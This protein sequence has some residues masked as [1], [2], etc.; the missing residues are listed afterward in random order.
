MKARVVRILVAAALLARLPI[1]PAS[2]FPILTGVC[3]M[4]YEVFMERGRNAPWRHDESAAP[5]R[6]AAYWAQA[7]HVT[8]MTHPIWYRYTRFGENDPC[9]TNSYRWL[10]EAMKWGDVII[11]LPRVW[12][13]SLNPQTWAHEW[14]LDDRWRYM[15]FAAGMPADVIERLL[16]GEMLDDLGEAQIEK[17]I[18]IFRQRYPLLVEA[19][20]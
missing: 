6:V 16:R 2:A 11:P 19:G 4:T 9:A 14:I 5:Q 7:G 18:T 10:K 20:E 12:R 3:T 17:L 15:V 13:W 8:S 1:S